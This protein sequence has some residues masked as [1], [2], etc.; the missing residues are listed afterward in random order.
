M[1]TDVVAENVVIHGREDEAPTYRR[2]I[3]VEQRDS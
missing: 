3:S 1:Q 2:S